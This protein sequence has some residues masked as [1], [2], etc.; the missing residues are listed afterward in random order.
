MARSPHVL[1]A[2]VEFVDGVVHHLSHRSVED[3]VADLS[4]AT[5]GAGAKI[6]AA[7]D[8]ATE[9]RRPVSSCAD[10]FH[11][12]RPHPGWHPDHGGRTTRRSG[13][14]AQVGGVACRGRSD[15][16]YLPVVGMALCSL[17]DSGELRCRVVG[18]REPWP[19][20][21]VARGHRCRAAP[22]H[23]RKPRSRRRAVL[24]F[25]LAK[26]TGFSGHTFGAGQSA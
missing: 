23:D 24:R 9:E 3:T 8:Q 4:V 18:A 12:V 20:A 19:A 21:S 11:R 1:P 13:P 26:T 22:A 7:I 6:F 16:D 10:L 14:S 5:E 2:G 15:P 17:R 25:P